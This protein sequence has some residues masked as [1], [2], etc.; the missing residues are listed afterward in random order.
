ME[1]LYYL[2]QIALELWYPADE[3]KK[4]VGSDTTANLIGLN[5]YKSHPLFF[6]TNT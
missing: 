5:K 6:L 4:L 2:K 1:N 3:K